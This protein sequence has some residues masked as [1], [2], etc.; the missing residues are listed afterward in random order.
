[1]ATAY[2]INYVYIH[3][4]SLKP[5][6]TRLNVHQIINTSYMQTTYIAIS[7]IVIMLS[8]F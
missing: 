2:P 8:V 6:D 4:I 5:M 3:F 1:M 7:D